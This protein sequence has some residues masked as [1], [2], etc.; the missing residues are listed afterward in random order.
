MAGRLLSWCNLRFCLPC[1]LCRFCCSGWAIVELVQP[2]VTCTDMVSVPSCSG[3]AIIELVQP[4]P[5]IREAAKKF[6]AV[7]GRLLS[8]CNYEESDAE[9]AAWRVAV[10]GRLL[11]WCNTHPAPWT[12]PVRPRCS[13]WAIVELVQQAAIEEVATEK[14]PLQWLGDC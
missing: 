7:A 13:G 3:W 12:Y 2:R 14:W 1:D 8:W 10:A 9:G 5:S 11:S 6:V 4:L